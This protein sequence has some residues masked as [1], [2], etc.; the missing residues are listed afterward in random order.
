[1][2]NLLSLGHSLVANPPLMVNA[3]AIYS[4]IYYDASSEHL[5]QFHI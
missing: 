5:I 1:M 3:G 4:S 2:C